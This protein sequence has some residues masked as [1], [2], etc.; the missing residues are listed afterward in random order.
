MCNDALQL[1]SLVYTSLRMDELSRVSVPPP[2]KT[3][4][5]LPVHLGLYKSMATGF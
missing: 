5:A 4:T 1:C 3:G 2:Q